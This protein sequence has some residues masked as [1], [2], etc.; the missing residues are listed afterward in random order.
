MLAASNRPELI[1]PAL[2]RPGAPAPEFHSNPQPNPTPNPHP[3]LTITIAPIL[4]PTPALVLTLTRTLTLTVSL[5]PHPSPSSC[6]HP[7]RL[8]KKLCVPFPDAKARGAVLETLCAPLPLAPQLR[9]PGALAALAARCDGFSGADL[10]A[11]APPTRSWNPGCHPHP[12]P[13][14][15][16]TPNPHPKPSP[17]PSPSPHPKQLYQ[18]LAYDAQLAAVQATLGPATPAAAAAAATSE[19]E[20]AGAGVADGA[21]AAAV[22][23]AAAAVA[24]PW[25]EPAAAWRELSA[26]A[27]ASR[28][29]PPGVR[30]LPE[31]FEQATRSLYLP[32]SPYMSLYL[33]MSPY[34][35]L[36]LP[37]TSS[38]RCAARAPPYIS[39]YLP[40][41]P[42]IS[43]ISLC[44]SLY[45][46]QAM[47]S[48]RASTTPAERARRQAADEAFAAGVVAAAGGPKRVT[49]A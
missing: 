44:I 45:L 22:A 3:S 11:H 30:I 8:D 2:L 48:T 7:G 6:P 41:S 25:V 15:N 10:Q 19:P 1:D 46:E 24:L 9:A 18:A 12:N 4:T 17:N 32:I 5:H 23:A 38:R 36:Y 40:I 28:A 47:R 27:E 35:S 33:P 16:P 31:H 13:G 29:A 26:P 20:P 49:L 37:S 21:M 43:Y 42:Y 39:L 34:I 14:R